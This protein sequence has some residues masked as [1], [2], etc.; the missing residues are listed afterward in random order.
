MFPTEVHEAWAPI[1]GS[2]VPADWS[3]VAGQLL[4]LYSVRATPRLRKVRARG[5]WTNRATALRRADAPWLQL[6]VNQLRFM[7]HFCWSCLSEVAPLKE[8]IMVRAPIVLTRRRLGTAGPNVGVDVLG[9]PGGRRGQRR[10]TATRRSG[11][12]SR[13]SATSL[14]RSGQ[15]RPRCLRACPARRRWRHARSYCA[16]A[17]I[18]PGPRASSSASAAR[19]TASGA[20]GGSSCSRSW[21]ATTTPRAPSTSGTPGARRRVRCDE[22]HR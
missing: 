7:A 20:A 11:W 5:T 21:C 14:A 2:A 8:F 18:G 19:S 3:P 6:R 15:R 17:D 12:C 10:R 1:K 9:G 22:A 13:P 4:H 16:D